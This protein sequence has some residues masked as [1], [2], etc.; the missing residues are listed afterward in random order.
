MT[1]IGLV[2]AG[3]M[4]TGLGR[5][6]MAG[7]HEVL[8]TTAGRSAR[9]Q[10]LVAAAGIPTVADLP[11]LAARCGLLLVVTPPAQAE[12]AAAQIADAARTAGSLPLVADLNAVSPSTVEKVAATLGAAGLDLVDGTISGSPPTPTSRTL[13]YLSG[14]R[15]D[16]VAALRWSPAEPIVV[17]PAVGAASAVKMCTASVYKGLS[18]LLAQALR[19]AD[20]HGVLDHVLAD[21]VELNPRPHITVAM[22]TTKADRFVGEMEQISATQAG[23]G[24]TPALFQAYAEIYRGLATTE[25]A[26]A[27]PETLDRSLTPAQVLAR[28]RPAQ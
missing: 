22:A 17:G 1:S 24:L 21:L 11:T 16:E 26:K 5:V 2:G 14:P 28:L 15:A 19:T 9:T 10:R 23:A 12:P 27:D 4:G 20:H 7:G 3:F 6:L 18:G 8:T 13:I 25:M